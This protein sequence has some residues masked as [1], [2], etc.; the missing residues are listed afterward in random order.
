M[1]AEEYK[2]YQ[3]I[4]SKLCEFLIEIDRFDTVKDHER[5]QRLCDAFF[6]TLSKKD[7]KR[8]A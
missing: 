8:G 1:S 2:A 5:F 3:A 7:V 6:E 4:Q